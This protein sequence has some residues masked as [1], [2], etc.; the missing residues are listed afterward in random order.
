MI[1]VET[2]VVDVDTVL[3]TV[4]VEVAASNPPKGENRRIVESGSGKEGGGGV[5]DGKLRSGRA[6]TIHPSLGEIM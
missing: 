4:V 5:G 6:P 2:A 3:M 1:A